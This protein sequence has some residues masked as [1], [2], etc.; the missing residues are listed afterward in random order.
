MENQKQ[1]VEQTEKITNV[2]RA[3]SV[4]DEITLTAALAM[5][6]EY[7]EKGTSVVFGAAARIFAENFNENLDENLNRFKQLIIAYREEIDKNVEEN[8]DAQE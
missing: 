7:M 6:P 3:M 8:A 4:C 1:H 2:I 5:L